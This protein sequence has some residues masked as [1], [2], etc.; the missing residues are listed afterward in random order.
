MV[1][2]QRHPNR[3][4]RTLTRNSLIAGGSSPLAS[5]QS[6]RHRHT[7]TRLN[8][9]HSGTTNRDGETPIRLSRHQHSVCWSERQRMGTPVLETPESNNHSVHRLA[10]DD[11]SYVVRRCLFPNSPALSRPKHK[12]H[13]T[14]TDD[15]TA[16]LDSELVCIKTNASKRRLKRL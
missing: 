15:N 12:H 16:E 9:P 11:P 3:T 14:V 6:S 1:P 10:E 8:S 13:S 7:H 2:G 5:I 4:P